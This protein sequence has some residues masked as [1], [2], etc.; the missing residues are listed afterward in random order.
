M[1]NTEIGGLLKGL[2]FIALGYV[3]CM[4]HQAARCGCNRQGAQQGGNTGIVPPGYN[5]SAH[6]Y[7]GSMAAM[8]QGVL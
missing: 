8:L 7:S 4:H 1:N 3:L 5:L 6:E 2:A